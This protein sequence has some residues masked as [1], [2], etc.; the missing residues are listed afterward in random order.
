MA[1]VTGLAERVGIQL[2]QKMNDNLHGRT[3]RG[4]SLSEE[5]EN[6]IK[7]FYFKTD[8]VYTAPGLRDQCRVWEDGKKK[9]TKKILSSYVLERNIFSFQACLSFSES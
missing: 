5:H 6:L 2:N 9:K 3:R 1:A 7:D 4:V 8:I